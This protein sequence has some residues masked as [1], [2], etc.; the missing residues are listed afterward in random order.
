M[1]TGVTRAAGVAELNQSTVR[2]RQEVPEPR[3]EQSSL[4]GDRSRERAAEVQIS[5]RAVEQ[6][7]GVVQA[8]AESGAAGTL[9]VGALA[10]GAVAAPQEVDPAVRSEQLE[11]SDAMAGEV[12]ATRVAIDPDAR[13]LALQAASTEAEVGTRQ[14]PELSANDRSQLSQ[15]TAAAEMRETREV[16]PGVAVDELGMVADAGRPE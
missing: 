10:F 5:Q 6:S 8:S 11:S 13:R 7:Q 16:D 14:A 9:G 12:Q 4:R 3:N 2:A 1:V 15:Q